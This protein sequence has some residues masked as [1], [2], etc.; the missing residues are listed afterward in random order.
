MKHGRY[1]NPIDPVIAAGGEAFRNRQRRASKIEARWYSRVRM[2]EEAVEFNVRNVDDLT[3]AEFE[4]ALQSTHDFIR[5]HAAYRGHHCLR[6]NRG[7]SSAADR[8]SDV[9]HYVGTPSLFKA[10]DFSMFLEELS[11]LEAGATP[12]TAS[13]LAFHRALQATDERM[14]CSNWFRGIAQ[15]FLYRGPQCFFQRDDLAKLH[16]DFSTARA[17]YLKD[18]APAT[19]TRNGAFLVL[20]C[21]QC[22]K[23]R[24]VDTKTFALHRP[25]VWNRRQRTGRRRDLLARAPW[26]QRVCDAWLRASCEEDML[27]QLDHYHSFVASDA[28]VAA[29]S[30]DNA[31]DVFELFEDRMA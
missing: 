27:W 14:R 8:Y 18:R 20:Q 1:D 6:E 21:A 12:E 4:Q 19:G 5:K 30:K 31:L 15:E 3:D 9:A 2:L 24:R 7:P 25:E 13:E 17:E 23:W 11:V 29:I 22:E 26:M 10:Y 28:G 16:F